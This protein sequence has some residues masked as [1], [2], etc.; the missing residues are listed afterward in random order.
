MFS[1]SFCFYYAGGYQ[2]I[3]LP[4]VFLLVGQLCFLCLLF[5]VLIK[6]IIILVVIIIIIILNPLLSGYYDTI[7]GQ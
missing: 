1:F 5:Y 7:I 4:S 2:W 3:S 6:I